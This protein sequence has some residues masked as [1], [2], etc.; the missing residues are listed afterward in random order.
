MATDL[1]ILAAI[2]QF[3]LEIGNQQAAIDAAHANLPPLGNLAREL[4][5]LSLAER[6]DRLHVTVIALRDRGPELRRR[7]DQVLASADQTA[8]ATPQLLHRVTVERNRLTC[9]QKFIAAL[10]HIGEAFAHSFRFG[11]NLVLAIANQPV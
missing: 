11:R 7:L 10:T 6:V 1:K 8:E 4:A 2:N 5:L 3:E 9:N